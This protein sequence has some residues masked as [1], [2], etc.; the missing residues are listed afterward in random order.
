[1]ISISPSFISLSW[2]VIAYTTISSLIML[3]MFHNLYVTLAHPLLIVIFG[4]E[5]AFWLVSYKGRDITVF[6]LNTTC[7]KLYGRHY[8]LV[9]KFQLSLLIYTLF[10][11]A[12]W[13]WPSH[14]RARFC[15]HWASYTFAKLV[16]IAKTVSARISARVKCKHTPS[17]S[18]LFLFICATCNL[19]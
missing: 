14:G 11:L 19:R 4:L 8:D 17:P 10:T 5:V 16:N 9:G 3:W 15:L 13:P 7:K 6:M 1:M 12:P 18:E 2:V